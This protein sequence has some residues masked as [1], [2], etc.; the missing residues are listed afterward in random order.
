M[1]TDDGATLVLVCWLLQAGEYRYLPLLIGSGFA[2]NYFVGALS[3]A[4]DIF[5]II[6]TFLCLLNYWIGVWMRM[7]L[8]RVCIIG[9]S[10]SLPVFGGIQTHTCGWKQVLDLL[11][12]W[13]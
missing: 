7:N 9:W 12:N 11:P 3:S 13:S 8:L 6:F 5:G 2:E 10:P 4:I 1:V